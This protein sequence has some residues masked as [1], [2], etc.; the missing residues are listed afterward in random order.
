MSRPAD[1]VTLFATRAV[2]L[3]AYGLLSVVLVLH[4]E[5]AGLDQPRIGALLTLTLLGDTALS[6]WITTRADRIGRRRM[7]VAGALLMVLAGAA[8]SATTAFPLLLLAATVGVMSPSGNEVGP[9]LAIEQAALTEA[10]PAGRR[11]ATFA[12]YQLAGAVATAL[13]ALAGG[14]LAGGLQRR[15]LAPLASYRA[16]TALYGALGLALAA[17]FLRLTSR[18]ETAPRPAASPRAALLGLH[19][20]RRV[21]LELS[22]L[23]SLDAFAGGLVV[24]SFV[25]WWF[26]RRFGA[27]PATIGAI[28]FGA[29]VLA[30]ISA[31]SASAIARRIGLVNTMVATHLPSNLLLALVPLM[32]TLPLAIGVL[33][34]RFSISQMDVPTRQSYT[35]AVVDPDERSAAA[36]VTG[37]AR[38]VGSALAPAVAGPLYAGAGA[39]ASVPFLVAGGLKVLYDLLLWRRFRALRPPEER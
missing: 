6:L 28:F 11:T 31:L 15:G 14:A 38:T 36:G 5:A 29:N 37:I 7:L 1:V 33:L 27:S 2:R 3:F 4:L 39:L 20:S 24:Q 35:V 16:V 13:G 12:W 19:R 21:V 34:L 22:A 32:P 8:F 18:V 9:F 25:A 17:L 26:H 30:G 23:F 10:V